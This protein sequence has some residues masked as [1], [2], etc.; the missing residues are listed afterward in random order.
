MADM[1]KG[2]PCS[3]RDAIKFWRWFESG[4]GSRITL[5]HFSSRHVP[6][7]TR[8]DI[9]PT[10]LA[11]GRQRAS[12]RYCSGI[13]GGLQCL[14]KSGCKCVWD[15]HRPFLHNFLFHIFQ[16]LFNLVK[17]LSCFLP[18]ITTTNHCKE[19]TEFFFH[20][21]ARLVDYEWR[22]DYLI[23]NRSISGRGVKARR[24]YNGELHPWFWLYI[25]VEQT[26]IY[27][28]RYNIDT[29]TIHKSF[30]LTRNDC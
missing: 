27:K 2:W 24:C 13:G 16:L 29:N 4:C 8:H 18:A 20:C 21:C 25:S 9:G 30:Y 11:R 14:N 28:F 19:D 6:D 23:H 5:F 15:V 22:F 10:L 26:S 1:R 12:L 17:S 7:T 3:C